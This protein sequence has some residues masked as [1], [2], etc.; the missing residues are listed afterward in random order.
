MPAHNECILVLLRFLRCFVNAQHAS[1]MNG[2][3]DQK[4]KNP[5]M[6]LEFFLLI[7][8]DNDTITIKFFWSLWVIICCLKDVFI[9]PRIDYY[10]YWYNYMGEEND[11]IR[12]RV[13]LNYPWQRESKARKKNKGND[14]RHTHRGTQVYIIIIYN[15]DCSTFRFGGIEDNIHTF[16]SRIINLICFLCVERHFFVAAL[17]TFGEVPCTVE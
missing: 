12:S 4:K 17:S 2:R 10:E 8:Y 3:F 7:H 1:C 11:S 14:H 9:W 5:W 13:H 16:F 6:T 15:Y